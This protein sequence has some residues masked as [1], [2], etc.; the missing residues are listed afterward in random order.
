[1]RTLSSFRG[2]HAGR[3]IVV[4]GCGEGLNRLAAPE[5]FVAVGVNDV[6]RR[7]TPD[8]L[9]VINPRSQYKGDRFSYVEQSRA[10]YLFTQLDLGLRR[11]GV[12]KFRLGTYGGTDFNS[13]EVLHYTQN[14]PYV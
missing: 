10:R 5:R 8:Y 14:S 7:F 9:V 2:A 13:A 1:M 3:A 4:C 11:E 12:V 6:G